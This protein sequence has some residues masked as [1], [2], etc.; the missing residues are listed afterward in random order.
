MHRTHFRI[1]RAVR[2]VLLIY[3]GRECYDAFFERRQ[4]RRLIKYIVARHIEAPVALLFNGDQHLCDGPTIGS[5]VI[6]NGVDQGRSKASG[7]EDAA[8]AVTP[9]DKIRSA[10]FSLQS[11]EN[12]SINISPCC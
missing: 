12:I 9:A 2:L 6:L 5:F 4:D 7:A 8:K 1:G 10:P 11:K 3:L